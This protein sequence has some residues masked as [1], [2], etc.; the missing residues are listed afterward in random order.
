[1][2]PA[3]F[4]PATPAIERLQ[5]HVSDRAANGIVPQIGQDCE[6]PRALQLGHSLISLQLNPVFSVLKTLSNNHKMSSYARCVGRRSSGFVAAVPC[7]VL[8]AT[9]G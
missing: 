8:Q 4:E 7:V 1:M 2:T 6:L 5:T 3:G 9:R